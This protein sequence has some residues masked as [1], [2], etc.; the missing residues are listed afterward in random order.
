MT[1]MIAAI[2]GNPC[3]FGVGF[4]GPHPV[5]SE[6]NIELDPDVGLVVSQPGRAF[7]LTSAALLHLTRKM[8]PRDALKKALDG[9]SD[10]DQVQALVID[11]RGQTAAHSG[12]A[13]PPHFG[14]GQGTDHVAG[15]VA[16]T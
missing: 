6:E 4:A 5:G 2:A 7:Q 8:T 1:L 15:G 13:L 3:W 14:H 16:L 11:V 12:R 10:N 9:C